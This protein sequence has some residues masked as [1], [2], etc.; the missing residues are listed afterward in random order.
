[1]LLVPLHSVLYRVAQLIS[2]SSRGS[3]TD[4]GTFS[5]TADKC[6]RR[7]R[8]KSL[9]WFDLRDTQQISWQVGGRHDMKATSQLV[10]T[11]AQEATVI[12]SGVDPSSILGRPQVEAS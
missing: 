10:L 1:M 5:T 12:A 4:A 9:P 6:C 3:L 2:G 8:A 7:H 11:N